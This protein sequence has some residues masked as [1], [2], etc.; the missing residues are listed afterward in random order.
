MPRGGSTSYWWLGSC[1]R[2]ARYVTSGSYC[3]GARGSTLTIK[4]YIYARL[5]V[6]ATLEEVWTEIRRE[7]P[8]ARWYYVL[9]IAREFKRA[10]R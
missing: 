1:H 6:G 3:A 5:E 4:A 9:K 8:E 2:V 7:R 10:A